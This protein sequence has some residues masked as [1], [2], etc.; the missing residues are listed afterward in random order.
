MKCA[1]ML[2]TA[3]LA[4]GVLGFAT[5]SHAQIGAGYAP[6]D[7]M[8]TLNA[9]PTG[10]AGGSFNPVDRA[11]GAAAA[12]P[13]GAPAGRD[14]AMNPFGAAAGRDPGM[15]PFGAPGGDP[16][17]GQ[18]GGPAPG[19]FGAQPGAFGQPGGFGQAATNAFQ[20]PA[21]LT[22]W[23]GERIICARTGQILQDARELSILATAK[24]NYYDDGENGNDAVAND[25]TWTN[26]TINDTD[27]IS[28]EAHFVKSKLIQTLQFV[29]P[30]PMNA[31]KAGSFEQGLSMDLQGLVARSD[32]SLRSY[33]FRPRKAETMDFFSNLT[34]M[35]FNQV[36][37][38]TTEPLSPLP[39]M[40]DLERDQDAKL[41]Q[42]GVMFLSDYRLD[43]DDFAGEFIPT[44]LPFPPRAPKAPLPSNFSPMTQEEFEAQQESQQGSGGRGRGGGRGGDL[45]GGGMGAPGEPMGGASSRYF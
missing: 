43:P 14:P 21:T 41:R 17:G 11:R 28:P 23:G 26:I 12:S 2:I 36:R 38:A 8:D 33:L 45:Y 32:A 4:T 10:G 22:A 9:A 42:W 1:K 18:P 7:A 37:V 29:S 44:F 13:Y 15:N 31:E 30:P 3:M 34:P 5:A 19:A 27:Y 35:E 20:A 39:K 6:L 16:F 40:V 24:A 25:N